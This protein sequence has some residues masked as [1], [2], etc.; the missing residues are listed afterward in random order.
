M[1]R[2]AFTRSFSGNLPPGI[3][4]LI[5]TIGSEIPLI[6]QSFLFTLYLLKRHG[7]EWQ[8][9]RFYEDW[10]LRAF[11]AVLQEISP[12]GEYF[13]PEQI[14]RSCYSPRCLDSFAGFFGLAEIQ[15]DSAER[16]NGDF[17]L[18][19]LPLLDNVVQFHL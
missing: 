15:R 9:G 10:F 3:T 12:V 13:S 8:T 14:L 1:G 18:R 2:P 6:Q 4:G 11:P 19:K 17:R 16:Y 7:T 5:E